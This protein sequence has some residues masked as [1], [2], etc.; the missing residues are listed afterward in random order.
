MKKH[1]LA[2]LLL[3]LGGLGLNAQIVYEDFE[4]GA[5]QNWVGLNGAYNGAV[6]NPAPDAVNGSA[7]VGSYTNNIGFDFC[8][9]LADQSQTLDASEYNQF[10]MK[11]WS[12]VATGKILLKLETIGGGAAVEKIVDIQGANQWYEY[13][14]DLSAGAAATTYNRILV[15]FN[16]FAFDDHTFF[17]DD[18]KADKAKRVI[19]DWETPSGIN[20]IS[21]NG[22]FNGAVA[23]PDPNQVNSSATVGSFSNAPAFDYNFAFGTL[24]QALDLSVFNQFRFSLWAPQPTQ[25]LFKIEGA[26][27]AKEKVINVAV[28]NEWQEYNVDFSDAAGFTTITKILIVFS[29]GVTGSSDTYYL[30]NIYAVPNLCGTST[31]DPEVLDDYDCNR[32]AIYSIGWD[33]LHVVKNPYVTGDNSSNKVGQWNRPA[34]PGTE[35]A[36]LVID[37]ENPID[38]SER[39]QFSVQVWAPK[40]GTM[41]LKI[42]G[43]NGN[44][45]QA[46]QITQTQTW[47]TYT[48]DFSSQVGLGHKKLVLFFGAGA[49]GEAGDVYY[50]D[51]IRLFAPTEQAPIEDFQG[52]ATNLGWLPLDFVTALHGNFTGPTNNP[53][54]GGVNTSTQTGCYSKGSSPNS[55]LQVLSINNFNLSN[56]PQFNIDVLS[57]ATAVAGQTIVTM[58]L[59]SPIS[60][61][62]AVQAKIQTPGEWE[63]LKF[64]FSAF[65]AVTDFNEIRFLFDPNNANPGES[66]CVDNLRQSK[67]TTDPCADAV[68]NPNIVDDF[69]CQR[70][71]NQIFY[72]GADVSV[73]NNP[74]LNNDNPSSKVGQY[75]DPDGEPYAGIG[76]E[77]AQPIDLSTYNQLSLKVWSANA[78][79]P[80]LFKLE[81]NGP[82]VEIFDTLTEANKWFTFNIDF[83]A[84]NPTLHNKLVIFFNVANDQGGTYFVDDVKWGRKGYT[85]CVLDF[86]TPATTITAFNYFDQGSYNQPFE[87]VDN[88]N[89]SGINTSAKVGKFVKPSD[90][91][92]F[93][94]F[95]TDLDAPVDFAGLKQMRAKVLMDHLGVF[96]LKVEQDKSGNNFGWTEI[97][98]NN[99]TV[100]QWEETVHDF[101]TAPDGAKYYRFTIFFDWQMPGNGSSNVISYFDDIVIGAGECGT[102]G[103]WQPLPV[104]AMKVSPNPV[105]DL[106]YVENFDNVSRLEIFN[107]YGQRVQTVNTNLD[108]K[109]EVNVADLPV[110]VYVLAGYNPQ[111]LLLGNAKFVKQ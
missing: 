6:A 103:T 24:P 77:F 105:N 57:P 62:E 100:N 39:N 15:S 98:F 46:F 21:L 68:P 89:P 111:G 32:N 110:G 35:Y 12:P 74:H 4:G 97:P 94:G 3:I 25:V 75:D 8:F 19:E 17:F 26:G 85:G 86:E 66:W 18:I 51:N 16:S 55:T 34:G 40:T 23:N 71:Y 69:E 91:G 78:N 1:F 106:L 60:G 93:T 41:L 59:V 52:S 27:E 2:L 84:A 44:K 37:Y 107:A 79:V 56:Y 83:S 72:G 65:S 9:A 76:F 31:P 20:W 28:A 13:T 73:I 53:A 42:E 63:T 101:T 22:A 64:D 14:F 104:E 96:V 33:S 70:N 67:T 48:A 58:Q 81:G 29:P 47:V 54:P 30:D 92:N 80:F 88:P 38:L 5:S 50:V 61:N 102:I 108:L 87:V 82:G 95:Y 43:P 11:V 99:T 10:K 49:N 7:T 109:V 90:G 45:E 36:A